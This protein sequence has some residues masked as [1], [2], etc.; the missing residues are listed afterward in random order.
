MAVLAIAELAGR[1]GLDEAD[2]Q[3]RTE[4]VGHDALS[5]GVQSGSSLAY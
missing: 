1:L 2:E 4:W 3:E 5:F